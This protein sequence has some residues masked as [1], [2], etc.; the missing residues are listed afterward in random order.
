MFCTLNKEGSLGYKLMYYDSGNT[1]YTVLIFHDEVFPTYP[2]NHNTKIWEAF[3][4][5]QETKVK[6]FLAVIKDN[7]NICASFFMKTGIILLHVHVNCL[8]TRFFFSNINWSPFFFSFSLTLSLFGP[9][10]HSCIQRQILL[11]LLL[12]IICIFSAFL[13]R[14]WA[15]HSKKFFKKLKKKQKKIKDLRNYILQ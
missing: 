13:F 2:E 11:G 5:N 3:F 1:L 6:L 4:I 14:K 9:E 15:A 7:T 8:D 12:L 10:M